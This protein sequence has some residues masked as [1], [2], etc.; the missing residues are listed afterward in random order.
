M[1]KSWVSVSLL[2]ALLA[3]AVNAAQPSLAETLDRIPEVRI[4]KGDSRTAYRDPAIWFEDGTYHLFFTLV[5]TEA[6]GAVFSYVAK[7]ESRDLIHWTTPRKLTPRDG[8]KDYSSPGNV[9]VDGE[10]RV[11]CFQSYPRP[12]NR[13]DGVVRYANQTARLYTMRSR[14]LREWSAPE[15]IRVKGPEVAEADMGRMIDPYLLR[16]RQGMWWCFYKQ[17]GASISRSTDLRNWT[18]VGRT[19]AGENVCVLDAGDRYVMFHSPTNGVGRKVSTDLVHWQDE[20][21]VETLGQ[22]QWQWAAGRLTAGAVLDA[23]K[24]PGVGKYLL[25]FHGSGPRSER[26]GDFDRNASIGLAWSDDLVNWSW[27]GKAQ[28]SGPAATIENSPL[29]EKRIDRSSGVVSYILKPG[30]FAFSQQSLYFISI[31]MTDDA[32]FILFH[33]QGPEGEIVGKSPGKGKKAKVR[34]VDNSK[35]LMVVDVARGTAYSAAPPEMG[36]DAR[37]WLD[38]KTGDVYWLDPAAFYKFNLADPTGTNRKLFDLPANYLALGKVKRVCM[39]LTLSPDCRTAFL[40]TVIDNPRKWVQGAI[41]L[42]TGTFAKWSET[43]YELAHGQINPANPKL[44]LVAL[45]PQGDKTK[46]KEI[47]PDA[48]YL[49]HDFGCRR[50]GKRCYRIHVVAPGK[51]V[52][53]IMTPEGVHATHEIWSKDGKW[54]Y[55]CD[56]GKGPLGGVWRQSLATRKS[57]RVVPYHAQHS[58]PSADNRYVVYDSNVGGWR[59]CPWRVEFFDT[60]TGRRS[61]IHSEMAALRPREAPSVRHPDPH[62]QFV[63]NDRYIVCTYNN[64]DGHMDLSIT[65]VAQLVSVKSGNENALNTGMEMRQTKE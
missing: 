62:P 25:F 35:K 60:V 21:G 61:I 6:D 46:A 55:W 30:R 20:G 9:V 63:A 65:P 45:Q 49:V 48:E 44:G 34:K 1:N 53:H 28:P 5:E 4:L 64:A 15:L 17:R 32:R 16:D 33:A 42:D 27:P 36:D 3:G 57:E 59:G 13:D 56:N 47:P 29:F 8:M 23:R 10:E 12:G 26:E 24:I 51:E 43:W 41:D 37:Q 14:D 39:H 52:D 22:A 38:V 7:V 50:P 11:L 54:I 31:S 19:E 40:D 58:M 18:P 2:F